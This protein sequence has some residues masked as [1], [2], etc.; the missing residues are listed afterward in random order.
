MAKVQTL[1]AQVIAALRDADYD[2]WTAAQVH[3][4]LREG[5]IA[6]VS[7]KPDASATL[8]TVDLVAGTEQSVPDDG[9][10]LLSVLH[11]V[12]A[13]GNPSRSVRRKAAE[14]LDAFT[15]SWRAATA[16]ETREYCIDDRTPWMFQV[17]PPAVAGAKLRISYSKIPPEYGSVTSSTETLV[18]DAYGPAVVEWALYRLFGHDVEGSVNIQRSQ[19]HLGNFANLLGVKI[20]N[21]RIMSPRNPEH[22]R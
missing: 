22:K 21:D 5:E 11:T 7:Y 12:T 4:A 8:S 6:V 10:R 2:N 15:P 14:D 16:G 19:Q 13:E 1:A 20:Q 17:N 3:G 18:S 9:L